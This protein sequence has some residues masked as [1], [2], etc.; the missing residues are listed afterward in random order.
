[1]KIISMDTNFRRKGWV[2]KILILGI[3]NPIR[4]DDGVG[5]YIAGELKHGL[6][7]TQRAMVDIQ[8]TSMAGL[9]LLD[10]L[11]GYDKVILID[12]IQT[13]EGRPG[14]IYRFSLDDPGSFPGNTL[15][16][17]IGIPMVLFMAKKM[18]QPI[19]EEIVLYAVEIE[20]K[21]LFGEGLTPAVKEAVYKVIANIKNELNTFNEKS[22]LMGMIM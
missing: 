8:D 2:K 11:A 13:E 9:S 4:Y 5:N 15:S 3:G 18:D 20:R 19:P 16:H 12:S 1:M 22:D 7:S 6:D 14:D 21:E 10:L 17:N